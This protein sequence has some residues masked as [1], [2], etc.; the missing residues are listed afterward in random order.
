MTHSENSVD[1][2][3]LRPMKPIDVPRGQELSASLRWPHRREDWAQMFRLSE[4]A[5][6]EIDDGTIIGTCFTT[7]QGTYATI[8]LV[9]VD[10]AYQGRKLGQRL[11]QWALD[12]ATG[13]TVVLTAT[14][15]GLPLYEKLG[16]RAFG[17]VRQFQA[18]N[19]AAPAPMD[20]SA[21]RRATAR[22]FDK[23]VQLADASTGFFRSAIIT[24]FSEIARRVL[25]VVENSEVVGF[26]I[27]RPFGHG[28]SI[29]PVVAG[30]AEHGR[31]LVASLLTDLE[32]NFV[33][34]D[35][36]DQSGLEDIIQQTGMKLVA[37]APTM[38]RGEKPTVGEKARQFAVATQ[39]LG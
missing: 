3:T 29:G 15:A 31:Q 26:G 30:N 17:I 36:V 24:E 28:F 39:A 27:S 22:D 18:D 14:E 2:I 13:Y 19:I 5:V 33:R 25:V 21:I 12:I 35:C 16:F 20:T 11:M 9:I 1:E 34:I 8:G 7:L 32:G 10:P 37:E 38:V 4:G 6:L 23:V